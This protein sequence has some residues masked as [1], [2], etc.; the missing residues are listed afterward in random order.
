M[1][2]KTEQERWV[3]TATVEALKVVMDEVLMI[4]GETPKG[5]VK[6]AFLSL[7]DNLKHRIIDVQEKLDGS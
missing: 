1:M 2:T 6:T 5:G 7:H 3:A 4:A